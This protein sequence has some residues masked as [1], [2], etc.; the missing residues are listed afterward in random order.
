MSESKVEAFLS[1]E[2]EQEVVK[3]IRIAE[4]KTSGEIRVHIESGT[5]LDPYERVHEVFHEL[6]MEATKD[7]NGVLIY[8]AVNNRSFVIYGDKGIN[9][10]VSKTFWNDTK[11][12]IQTHFKK[13]AFKNGI[14]EGI[15]KA[16]EEL[17]AHFP[18][19]SDDTNELSNEVSKG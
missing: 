10:V 8:I 16:G 2:E 9:E 11:E 7:R 15:L 12:V 5:K 19:R 3:A 13:G 4:K 1:E 18:Y 6:K 17:K 14:V